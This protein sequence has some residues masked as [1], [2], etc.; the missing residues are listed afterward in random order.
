MTKLINLE[1][2]PDAVA[3]KVKPYL[4]QMIEIQGENLL[5]AA[6]YGSAVGEDFLENISDINILLVCQNVDLPTLKK[7]LRQVG[8]GIRDRIPAPLFL[9][10][11]YLETSTD[12]FPVEFLEI[13]DHCRVLYGED[14]L[15]GLE[16]DL[17]NLRHQCEEQV[18]GKLVRI[19]GTYLETAGQKGGVD[20]LLKQSLGSLM[21]VFRNLP[22]LKGKEPA[23]KKEEVL[24]LLAR[25]FGLEVEVFLSIWRDRQDDEKIAGRDAEIYLERYLAQL[26]RL[27]EAVDAL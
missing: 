13:K 15:S 4:E 5:S 16:I 27:A 1:T 18:K 2:L 3:K 24:K 11:R 7:S 14:L 23:E 26:E 6:V 9:T 20:R 22:R 12:V 10:P 17:K 19:R 8:R 25:E 21:P